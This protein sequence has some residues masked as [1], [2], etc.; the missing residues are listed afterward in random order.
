MK[1]L[2][3]TLVSVSALMNRWII[4][5]WDGDG[6]IVFYLASPPPFTHLGVRLS[7][8]VE[9]FLPYE[10]T[11]EGMLERLHAYI[12]NQ[13]GCNKAIRLMLW[14]IC[15]LT[16]EFWL[17][18][19]H[20]IQDEVIGVVLDVATPYGENPRDCP[21]ITKSRRSVCGCRCVLKSALEFE[22]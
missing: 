8:Q 13:V 15:C 18:E 21:E 12:Q 9:P 11:C 20:P 19:S 6:Y 1:P 3:I 10:Y 22:M 14:F 7:V 16:E 4:R 2:T 17:S 5:S